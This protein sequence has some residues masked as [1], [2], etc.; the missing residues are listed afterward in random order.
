MPKN[1][2]IDFPRF[3]NVVLQ[4]SPHQGQRQF[5]APFLYGN[6]TYRV[7]IR[8]PRGNATT[9]KTGE[10][11]EVRLDNSP[12]GH[13]VFCELWK[14]IKTASGKHPAVE[15]A[16]KHV[17]DK[18]AVALKDRF[19]HSSSFGGGELKS[20]GLL[21]EARVEDDVLTLV[22]ADAA[23]GTSTRLARGGSIY[24]AESRINPFEIQVPLARAEWTHDDADGSSLSW[25]LDYNRTHVLIFLD[26]SWEEVARYLDSEDDEDERD[27][28]MYY[29]DSDDYRERQ[30][31]IFW[32]RE[33]ERDYD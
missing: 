3:F 33:E 27:D 2:P 14:Q 8:S 17:F 26:T 32:A 4:C 21:A 10:T 16:E 31:E 23:T 28:D 22:F 12:N 24:N 15:Q 13:V 6:K 7:V 29:D 20:L 25:A 9:C 30:E 5:W 11:W 1:L 18:C 19:R